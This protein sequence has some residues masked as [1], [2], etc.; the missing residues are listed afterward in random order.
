M[1][2]IYVAIVILVLLGLSLYLMEGDEKDNKKGDKKNNKKGN[3]KDDKKD[4]EIGDKESD[5]KDDI[6]HHIY[7]D[8]CNIPFDKCV[9]CDQDGHRDG[10]MIYKSCLYSEDDSFKNCLHYKD[11]I[12]KD[13]FCMSNQNATYDDCKSV[14]RERVYCNSNPKAKNDKKCKNK[15][16]PINL[17]YCVNNPK[18]NYNDCKSND[19]ENDYCARN[20]KVERNTTGMENCCPSTT[21]YQKD[22]LENYIKK[23]ETPKPF[24][25]PEIE[26]LS[27]QTAEE[28]NT[29]ACTLR[30]NCKNIEVT[31]ENVY[32]ARKLCSD[33]KL[34][35]GENDSKKYDF[36]DSICKKIPG[37][38][39][40]NF[41]D[42]NNSS[43]VDGDVGNIDE[44]GVYTYVPIDATKLIPYIYMLDNNKENYYNETLKNNIINKG[45]DDLIREY[46][47]CWNNDPKPEICKLFGFGVKPK[48]TN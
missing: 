22:Y 9:K 47:H 27:L 14:N 5:E 40:K 28:V 18:A 43:V 46:C 21:K 37:L 23:Y 45:Y 42:N 36:S 15:I 10:Q 35:R 12:Y 39:E 29:Y 38:V 26:E 2:K 19:Y 48:V 3:K 11:T 4:D 1:K 41:N 7:D 17:G 6:C 31:P 24:I 32:L 13:A 30:D 25:M 34:G 8:I 44:D 16:N 20:P 33:I